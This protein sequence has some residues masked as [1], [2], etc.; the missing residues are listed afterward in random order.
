MISQPLFCPYCN[1]RVGRTEP[2][3]AGDR[4][5]CPRCGESFAYRPPEE[6]VNGRSEDPAGLPAPAPEAPPQR[7]T[8]RKLAWGVLGVMGL[9][10]VLGLTWALALLF[11]SGVQMMSIGILGAYLGRIYQEVKGRPT[12]VI[13]RIVANKDD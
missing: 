8:N 13:S 1:A 6:G 4:L 2:L 5:N 7:P 3:H 10:A 12:F 9:M 11:F